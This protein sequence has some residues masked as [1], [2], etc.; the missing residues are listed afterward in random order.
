MRVP[1][2]VREEKKGID[3]P[4]GRS[5]VHPWRARSFEGVPRSIERWMRSTGTRSSCRSGLRGVPGTRF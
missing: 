2:K 3:H 5:R 1:V 4:A